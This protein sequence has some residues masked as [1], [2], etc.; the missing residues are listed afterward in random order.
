M[1][2]QQSIKI[3]GK[4]TLKLFKRIKDFQFVD[5]LRNA[6]QCHFY[7][8][9]IRYSGQAVCLVISFFIFNEAF[10]CSYRRTLPS[11]DVVRSRQ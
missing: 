4:D 5:F 1:H 2:G 7:L 10:D 6:M 3:C 9:A 11:S 8:S